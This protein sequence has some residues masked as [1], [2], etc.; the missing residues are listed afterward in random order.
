M[1]GYSILIADLPCLGCGVPR[2]TDIQFLTDDAAEDDVPAYALGETVP[3]PVGAAYDAFAD[4]FCHPCLDRWIADENDVAFDHLA[5]A[6]QRGDVVARRADDRAVIDLADLR[7][8][9]MAADVRGLIP[10][11]SARLARAGVILCDDDVPLDAVAT[12]WSEL[13]TDHIC[14]RL[15]ERGWP[16][17]GNELH[18]ED[19]VVRVTAAQTL[20]L[21]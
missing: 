16:P 12:M 10:T 2:R 14:A 15:V 11:L 7:P 8:L 20:E 19:L 21:G 18:R 1:G 3:L 13:H 4:A 6:I 9:A 17:P 5:A